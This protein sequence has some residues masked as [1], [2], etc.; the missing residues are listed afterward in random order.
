MRR[1]LPQARLAGRERSGK[2]DRHPDIG[3]V[4]TSEVLTAL[5]PA[6]A[7]RVADSRA[8]NAKINDPTEGP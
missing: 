5:G 4:A 2:L 7:A 3:P 1:Y 8:S 6:Y